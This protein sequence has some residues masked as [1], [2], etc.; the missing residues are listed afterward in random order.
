MIETT[1][2]TVTGS[3]KNP[4]KMAIEQRSMIDITLD[5]YDISASNYAS[6]IKLNYNQTEIILLDDDT[7]DNFDTYFTPLYTEK[8]DYNQW[9]KTINK[10]FQELGLE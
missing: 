5:P 3:I 1:Q 4:D 9:K 2:V 6:K 8:I 10:S 7:S